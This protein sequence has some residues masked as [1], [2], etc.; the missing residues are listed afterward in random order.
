MDKRNDFEK[1]VEK[2]AFDLFVQRGMT[3]G[4]D[5]DDW[6]RAEKIVM[7]RHASPVKNKTEVVMTPKRKGEPL[8]KERPGL[9]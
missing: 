9:I 7:A 3:N 4:H 1:E 6:F 8:K 2:M 5:L